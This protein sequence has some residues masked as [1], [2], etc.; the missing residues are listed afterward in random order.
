M[1]LNIGVRALK[2]QQRALNVT[3]HN[4]ANANTEGYSRQRAELTATT[5]YAIPSLHDRVQAGQVGTGVKV[6]QIIRLR[7]LFID[8]RFREETSNLG[9]WEQLSDALHEIELIFGEPSDL[10]LRSA[11]DNFWSSLQELHN[12]PES[13]AVRAAVRQSAAALADVFTALRGQL[14][15]FQ[16]ALDGYVKNKVEEINSYAR[17][18]ADLN[19]QI[20]LVVGK[21]DNPN[22]LMDE[23]DLLIDKLAS[24]VDIELNYD[25][26]G[27]VNITIGGFSLVAGNQNLELTYIENH[28]K[29]GM[30]DVKWKSTGSSLLLKS[31][32]LKGILEARDEIVADFISELDT[33]ASTFI[34]E[35]NEVHQ[36]GYGLDNSTGIKFFEGTDASNIRVSDDIMDE[37]NGL[38]RIAAALSMDSPG[39]GSNALKLSE[40]MQTGLLNGEKTTMADYWGGIITRLGVDSQRALHMVENQKALTEQLDQQRQSISGVSLDEEMANLI[41]YQHAYNAA[42]KLIQT[43]S[44]MLDTLVNGILR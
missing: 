5:P 27:K 22:D 42:A 9:K 36:N 13:G 34:V 2:A 3:G 16:W 15:D 26:T 17:R 23:R 37:I 32:E 30:V 4:I 10:G 24:L 6:K 20:S 41:R 21:G 14:Q 33:M 38:N 31:G 44:E 8:G 11:L 25:S 1:G 29:N 19:K 40:V 18:I 43:Q 39:D 7:N 28:S 35:F 12:N